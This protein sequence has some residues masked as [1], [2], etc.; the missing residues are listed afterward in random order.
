MKKIFL[1]AL[2]A[3]CFATNAVCHEMR[4]AYLQ[5]QQIN[6]NTYNVFWK[7]P[8]RGDNMRLSL[9]VE[10]PPDTKN[11]TEPQAFFANGASIE[12]WTIQR[13]GGLAGSRIR[14]AGLSATLTDVLLRLERLDSSTQVVRLT[15][16]T[17]AFTVDATSRPLKIA[18]TYLQ[19]GIEHILT[20]VD[21]LL[22]VSGLLLLVSGFGRVVKTISAF[23]VSHSVT[24]TLASLGIVNIPPPPVEAVIALSILFVAYEILK[25]RNE[26]NRLSQQKPWLIAFLFGLLHGLGFAGGLHE[27]GLPAGHIPLALALFSVGVEVGHFSFVAVVFGSIAMV[28]RLRIQ[29][30]EWAW[31]IPPYAIGGAAAYWLIARIAVFAN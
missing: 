4:P 20:G 1:F 11:V 2:L 24:L 28:R 29:P 6:A 12:R 22:F 19:L 14:I 8:A 13:N 10:F 30:P 15:A 18:T 26:P 3:A 27:A 16:A 25:S 21:H 5:L 9:H 7:V 31:R 17:P 23:T